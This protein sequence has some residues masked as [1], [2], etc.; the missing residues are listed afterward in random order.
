MLQST[1]LSWRPE[2]C[3]VIQGYIYLSL[4][5]SNCIQ[6]HTLFMVDPR[7]K[8]SSV[9]GKGRSTIELYERS[10][11]ERIVLSE[12]SIENYVLSNELSTEL[13]NVSLNPIHEH[14]I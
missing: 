10:T 8:M 12:P 1:W 13:S 14:H 11:E 3:P 7:E 6:K 5:R 9:F 2:S 4:I